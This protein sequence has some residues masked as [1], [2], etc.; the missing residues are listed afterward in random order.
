MDQT[1]QAL[2]GIVLNAVPTLL[3][4][5]LLYVYLKFMFFRPLEQV[6]HQRSEATEGARKAA[7][8][9]LARA[10]EKAAEYEKAIR[11][12]RSEIYKDQEQLRRKLRDDQAAAIREARE[13]ASKLVAEARE[14][15]ATDAQLARQ[16]LTAESE[17]LAE[18][19]AQRV[20]RRGAAA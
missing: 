13:D 3:I 14:R 2:G 18:E 10:S 12:A 20:L 5:L 4:V 19:I 16:G 7:E 6:L 8:T 1:L 17:A 15:I 9:S 11:D